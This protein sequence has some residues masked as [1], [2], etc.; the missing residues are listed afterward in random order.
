MI[1]N[2]VSKYRFSDTGKPLESSSLGYGYYLYDQI[3]DGVQNGNCLRLI[4]LIW[5]RNLNSDIGNK[6]TNKISV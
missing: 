5:T 3:Q 4:L 6:C 1:T 2:K